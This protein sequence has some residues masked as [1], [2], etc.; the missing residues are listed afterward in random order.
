[1]SDEDEHLLVDE[2]GLPHPA[3][4]EEVSDDEDPFIDST[5]QRRM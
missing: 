4:G 3:M 2:F 5:P 1:M